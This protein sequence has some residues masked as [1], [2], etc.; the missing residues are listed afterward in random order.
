MFVSPL[1][2]IEYTGQISSPARRAS[3]LR[4]RI[5]CGQQPCCA[6]LHAS[7]PCITP[8]TPDRSARKPF[9][10]RRLGAE[11]AAIYR[12]FRLEG[13]QSCPTA[14]SSS[15]DEENGQT[16]AKFADRLEKSVVLDAWLDEC[17]L[18]GIAGMFVPD[19]AKL[20]HKASIVGVYVRPE[21]R[22]TGLAQALLEPLMA[23]ANE[24]VEAL[25]ITVEACN[26]G[27]LRLYKKLGFEEYGRGP[28]PRQNYWS[29]F[30]AAGTP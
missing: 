12:S 19:M 29:N 23:H 4:R 30:S 8:V 18:C 28:P 14:F 2:M 21:A 16:M 3:R 27:A 26:I 6:N 5:H 9:I 17:T 22:G 25:L 1:P 20:R 10:F 7:F 11:D 24:Q 15:W 13:L